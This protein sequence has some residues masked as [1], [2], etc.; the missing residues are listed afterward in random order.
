MLELVGNSSRA[1]L[2]PLRKAL[3]P[4]SPDT[5]KAPKVPS[6]DVK[7]VEVTPGPEVKGESFEVQSPGPHLYQRWTSW[8]RTSG[9]L[10]LFWC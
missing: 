9:D 7:V 10:C 6:V 4:T 1:K 8:A 2:S 5:P 3:P